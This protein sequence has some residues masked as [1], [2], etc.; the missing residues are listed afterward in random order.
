MELTMATEQA[1]QVLSEKITYYQGEYIRDLVG[2]LLTALQ[3][4]RAKP[5]DDVWTDSSPSA[6]KATVNFYWI[7]NGI[8]EFCGQR[9]YER[10]LPKTRAREIAEE[11]AVMYY[12][13]SELIE[14][15][16]KTHESAILK[17]Q[18]EWE[19]GR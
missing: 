16:I 6:T 11:M 10:E 3:A 5:K 9:C 14:Q 13:H 4:E 18:A 12:G 17:A 1:E 19:A 2:V 15:L 8:K 7:K